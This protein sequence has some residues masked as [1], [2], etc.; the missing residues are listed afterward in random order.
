MAYALER[1]A[2]EIRSSLQ[3]WADPKDAVLCMGPAM[4][5]LAREGGD[6]WQL[7]EPATISSGLPGRRL[8]ADPEA[9]FTLLLAQYPPNT[10]T[11]VH[12]HEGWV[13]LCLL[14][15]SERYTSWR[16]AD[17]VADPQ[18][19]QLAVTQDHHLL[20]GDLA[21]LYNEP[22]NIH[23]Q[24]PQAQ[25]ATEVVLMAGRGRRL[26]NIDE[27]TGACESASDLGR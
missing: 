9:R 19:V 25:G 1:F 11:T 10:P 17:D 7:G 3:R 15:G 27:A 4:Q 24:W 18:R 6:L 26:L 13:V 16:R 22:F 5:K 2:D 14:D 20:P 12:S 21:Y 23:R 8:I